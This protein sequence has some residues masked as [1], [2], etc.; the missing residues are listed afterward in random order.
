MRG[1]AEPQTERSADIPVRSNARRSDGARK[2]GNGTAGGRCCGQ[3]CPRSVAVRDFLAPCEQVGLLQCRAAEPQPKR[4]EPRITR[5]ARI[6][7]LLSALSAKSAVKILSAH[8]QLRASVLRYI[9]GSTNF[10]QT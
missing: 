4:I 8:A 2:F 1:A 10:P 9:R 6:S 5:M 3:E 7:F